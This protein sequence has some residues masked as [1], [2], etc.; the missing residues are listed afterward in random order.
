MM[1]TASERHEELPSFAKCLAMLAQR[2]RVA[3]VMDAC[4]ANAR[5]AGLDRAH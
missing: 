4:G 5:V 1:F 3:A 2:Q